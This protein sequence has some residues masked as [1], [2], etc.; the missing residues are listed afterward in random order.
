MTDLQ[1]ALGVNQM[2]RLN[3][4]VAQRHKISSRYDYLL[5]NLPVTIPFQ[6]KGSY[7]GLHLYVI[8]LRLAEISLSHK[9]VFNELRA[10]GI[11]VNLH[12][13]PIHTQPY[14]QAMGFSWGDFPNAEKYYYE[15]ISL[16]MY[17]KLNTELQSKVINT[18][19]KILGQ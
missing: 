11:G 14:Y 1:A 9:Q 16:P 7:S 17:P 15:A 19:Y 5:K 13:I 2:R 8:R 12:Y 6:Q 10:N 18:L 3:E 4:F